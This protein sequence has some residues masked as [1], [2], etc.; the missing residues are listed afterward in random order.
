[1]RSKGATKNEEENV[2]SEIYLTPHGLVE[3][4]SSEIIRNRLGN[5]TSVVA[6]HADSEQQ[7][8][9]PRACRAVSRY[10]SPPSAADRAPRP[11]IATPNARSRASLWASILERGRVDG[12]VAETATDRIPVPG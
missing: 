7:C 2:R 6:A 5:G 3:E 1:M 4:G 9:R 8:A 11:A 10:R 12:A